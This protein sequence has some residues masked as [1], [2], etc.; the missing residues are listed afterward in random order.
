MEVA[1]RK[2]RILPVPMLIDVLSCLVLLGCVEL[3]T[4]PR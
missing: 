1:A 4:L 2:V 3:T